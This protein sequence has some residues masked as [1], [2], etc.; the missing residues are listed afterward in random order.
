MHS[1]QAVDGLIKKL[2]ESHDDAT[3]RLAFKALCR[4]DHREAD[5][6]GDWWT[7]R[8]DTSGPY[9]K[10]VAWDQTKKIER[11][12]RRRPEAGRLARRP[13]SCL[14]EL[15]RNKVELEGAA[16]VDIDLAGLEPSARAAVVD[17]LIARRSLPERATPLSRERG[18]LRQG[19]TGPAR[20]GTEGPGPPSSPVGDPRA[21]GDR[22]PG[23]A[24]AAS[25]STSWRDYL[26][27]GDH[28]RRV[29]DFRKLAEDEDPAARELGYAVLL[30]SGRQP[31]D[32][33]AGQ[34]RG[35]TGDRVRVED[36]A[37]GRQLAEGDRPDR[38]MKYAF[39]VRNRLKDEHREV[40]EAAAFAAAR[41]DLDRETDGADRG[42]TIAS[43][44]FESVLAAAMT[45]EG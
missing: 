40:K 16:A 37:R 29:G 9:Y 35:R 12:P 25:C 4:L 1:S 32:A 7:T 41:L 2:D 21:G 23:L 26:R 11:A 39:Q 14:V 43:I 31:E 20:Q 15:V 10:P 8:P 42:P 36:A 28:A 22:A 6:T 3:R 5:Y 19:S 45:R 44:P 30:A 33:G 38:S 24:P 17:I 18:G 13:A 27:D 34:G